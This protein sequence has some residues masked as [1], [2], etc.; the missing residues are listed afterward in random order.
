[1]VGYLTHTNLHTEEGAT[2]STGYT[3]KDPSPIPLSSSTEALRKGE[4]ENWILFQKPFPEFRKAGQHVRTHLPRDD[5]S[6]VMQPRGQTVLDQWI[7]FEMVGERFTQETLGYVADMFPQ[8]VETVYRQ[9]DLESA[10]T[11]NS[12][13]EAEDS[14]SSKSTSGESDKAQWAKFWFP[15]VVL[16]IEFQKALPP[17]GVEWLFSRVRSKRIRNGRMDL[18]VTI[19]DEGGDIV[20]L[21]THVALIVGAERNTNRKEKG[22]GGNGRGGSKL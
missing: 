19:L 12:E 10:L 7:C 14:K 20:A 3:L 6:S 13:A 4:D 16:N 2:L 18:E 21:S 9:G 11:R 8:I 22:E 5:G 15:T 17:E 1:M